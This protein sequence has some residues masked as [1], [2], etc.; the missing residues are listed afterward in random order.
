MT[1]IPSLPFSGQQLR[2]T[3]SALD[4][5][6]D[7]KEATGT[8]AAAVAAHVAAADPHPGYLTQSEGDARY[9]PVDSD[10]TAIAA[11][12]TTAYGRA[13]LA[14]ADAAA[15]RSALGLGS[16]ATAATGDFAA[17]SH[18]QT[19]STISDSTAV[20]RSVL[21]AVDAA[22][23]RTA[24]GAG[25]GNGTVTGVT[26]AGLITSS[27]GAAPVIST[28][29]ASGRLLGRSTAGTGAAEEITLGANLTLSAGVLSASVTGGGGGTVTS[30]GLSL[31]GLFSVSGSP[32]TTAGTLAAT[33][34]N[35]NAALVFAGP[36]TGVAAAPTFRALV[37]TDLPTI[38]STQVSGLGTFATADSAAPPA[39]GGTTPAAGSF[40]ALTATTQFTVPSGAP[41]SP[42]TRN[43]YA[44]ADTI[45]YRDS[46]NTERLLLNA[47]DNLANLSNTATARSN[48]GA[49]ASGAIGSSGLTMATAR[50]LGRTTASTGT[51][52]EI[53]V[54]TGLSLTG[55][56]LSATGG[57]GGMPS[58]GLPAWSAG[59]GS[60][61]APNNCGSGTLGNAAAAA[62][63]VEY[64]QI[65]IPE[66]ITIT[67]LIC[68]THTTYE[69]Q[70]I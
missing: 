1:T 3:L 38:P 65:Y 47:A 43:V 8:A 4:T 41:G 48:L 61:I 34:A 2:D 68:R 45:R 62:N 52:E 20:G 59:S 14:L 55:G 15:G 24:I 27:G 5:A 28:S 50:L 13:F 36:S 21:T 39:I 25:T 6:I 46:S 16:A 35:Q 58:P 53:T 19:A 49:A 69:V 32:V 57:G 33:L 30:V 37:A 22:A 31:P 64:H 51:P 17:A 54:G 44:V 66:T 9:Q 56:T 70:Q 60:I 26:G 11:L 67:Q 29:M 40:S 7:G 42:A 18:S 12:S 63:T 23:A 10:L